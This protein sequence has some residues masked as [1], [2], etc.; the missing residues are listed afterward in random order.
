MKGESPMKLKTR[1][2]LTGTAFILPFFLGFAL[3]YLIPFGWSVVKTFMAGAGGSRFVGLRN[4]CD[5][6]RSAAFQLAAGNTLR[7]IGVGVPLLMVLSFALALALYRKFRGASFF[8]SAFLLPL[9]IPVAAVVTVVQAF[10]GDG[11]LTNQLLEVL[12]LPVK[13]WLHSDLAFSLLIGL[14]IWKNCGY[15]MILF[16]AGLAAIPQEYADAAACE[17]ASEAYILRHI[18]LPL[19]VPNF[20]FVFVISVINAFKSFREAYLLGGSMP[21]ESIYML[22]HFMNNNFTNLNYPRLSTAAL[23]IFS[24]IFLLVLLL[25]CVKRKYEVAL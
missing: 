11:G 20:F 9:V 6:F 2:S 23:L 19:M 16:L 1:D 21:H 22:Q 18:T 3:L 10:F 25:F 12:G 15:N 24:G 4:Y 13:S 5:L 8:R 14:Y 17:G 7:F